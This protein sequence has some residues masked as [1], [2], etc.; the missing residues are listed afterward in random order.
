M[1]NPWKEKRQAYVR[2]AISVPKTTKYWC[3][4]SQ[5]LCWRGVIYDYKRQSNVVIEL[6]AYTNNIHAR[7]NET[8]DTIFGKS[9]P[10]QLTSCILLQWWFLYFSHDGRHSF[11]SDENSLDRA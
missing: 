3:W 1:M 8:H 11:R 10:I 9:N 6:L 5:F 7:E 2:G 4:L